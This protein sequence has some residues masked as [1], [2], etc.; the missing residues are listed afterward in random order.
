M[1]PWKLSS[2]AVKM[3]LPR[4]RA[5]EHRPAD[6]AG[7][8]ELA[9]QVDLE[10]VVPVLVGVLGGRGTGDGP[11]VVDQDVD[12]TVERGQLA[13]QPADGLRGP[14]GRPDRR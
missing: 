10:D 4:A 8:H 1:P 3:I 5:V 7:Q 13:E 12:R 14:R 11:G 9:G 6:L 2:D